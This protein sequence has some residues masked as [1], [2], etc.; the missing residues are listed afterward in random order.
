MVL[1]WA[2][3]CYASN[4][5][6]SHKE[7]R[8]L[9]QTATSEK[10]RHEEA[11]VGPGRSKRVAPGV[12]WGFLATNWWWN[13][14]AFLLICS[15]KA[16]FNYQ[17]FPGS[18][19]TNEYTYRHLNTLLIFILVDGSEIW[20]ETTCYTWDQYGKNE[21]MINLGDFLSC[22][23][24]NHQEYIPAISLSFQT[25]VEDRSLVIV[26]LPR[27]LDFKVPWMIHLLLRSG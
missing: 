25:L 1:G 21:N 11:E 16:G 9:R 17:E 23:F 19:W 7:L 14:Y 12:G 27:T 22:G 20:W 6:P 10:Q 26:H 24:L 8:V 3:F 4:S 15:L 2:P 13:F 18:L 5:L